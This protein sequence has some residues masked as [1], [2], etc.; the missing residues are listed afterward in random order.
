M[1]PATTR[2]A[3]LRE[4]GQPLVLEELPLP[5]EPEPGAAVVRIDR[6]T[7]CGTDAHLWQGGMPGVELPIV[8]GHEMVGTVVALGAGAGRDA[9]GR[10]VEIGTRLVWS[11]STCGHCH[12]CAVLREPVLCADRGYGFRQR[13]DRPPY[14][15]GGLAEY[16]YLPPG[17]ARLVV[18]PDMPHD[19]AAAAGCAVKTA[20][21]AVRRAGGIRHGETVVVQGA[22][23]LGLFGTALARAGGAGLVVTVGAPAERLAVACAWGADE[24]VSV[25]ELAEPEA[26][27]ARVAELTGPRGADLVLDFAGGPTA[28]HEGVLMCGQRGRHV[29]VG[30]AGPDARA[31]PLDLVMSREIQVLGSL[32]GDVSDLD[33]ALRFLE[34]FRDRFDFSAAFGAPAGLADATTALAAMAAMTTTKAVISPQLDQKEPA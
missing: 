11:E 5:A 29:V 1:S 3:V 33:G 21:R 16:C 13:A 27:V 31:L 24:V 4:Y 7:L 25:R 26:R 20:L 28:N 6:T 30:L 8:L 32:N 12:G 15:T 10:P 9:R 2:A 23:P 22:G 19:W 18:P 34:S 14:V 17:A